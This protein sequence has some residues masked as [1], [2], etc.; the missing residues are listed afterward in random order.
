MF[1]SFQLSPLCVFINFCLSSLLCFPGGSEDKEFASYVGDL[2]FSVCPNQTKHREATF[3]FSLIPSS[4]S[5]AF[6]ALRVPA[7]PSAQ[8]LLHACCFVVLTFILEAG[9]ATVPEFH[10]Q[11][12]NK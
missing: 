5:G 7:A 11:N 12:G 3:G 2:V 1:F 8:P 6:L 4:D 9:D 10:K